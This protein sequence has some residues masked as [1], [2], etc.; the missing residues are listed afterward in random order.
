MPDASTDTN[1]KRPQQQ[2]PGYQILGK[3]GSG[4]MATVYK[5]R[6]LSLDR[7]V[8]IKVL[9]K[10]MSQDEKFVERFY[11]EGKAAAQL[12]HA[13]IV[14]ALDVAKANDFHY[15]VMEYVE[16]HTVYDE[17]QEI[18]RYDEEDAVR[19]GLEIARAM[20]HAHAAGFIHR[21]I[22]PK[23][24]MIATD[25]VA[26]LMDMGLARA[27]S[28]SADEEEKGKALG[29]PDYI[30]PEQI[31]SSPDLDFRAD[32]YAF[33]AS[34]YHMVTGQVPFEGETAKEVMI[35]HL[36]DDPRPAIE[37]NPR[38]SEGLDGVIRVCLAKN[39]DARYET[40]RDLVADLQ[41]ISMGELPLKAE[42]KL[43]ASLSGDEVVEQLERE[44][45]DQGAALTEPT[46]PVG[47]APAPPQPEPLSQNTWFRVAV[48][49]WLCA[50]IFLVLWLM[51]MAG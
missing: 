1:S 11:A 28:E 40:T 26:K 25:G 37:I 49:G 29:T 2:I 48:V 8:A 45:L 39:P 22:K 12:N 13:N 19:I 35:R 15:F 51:A 47:D 33:G 17:L 20:E 30:A 9:P 38:I 5:A 4:G 34:L 43:G 18:I 16:G 14:G 21:D 42:V 24:F 36:K 46:D 3:L 44:V 23:N 6:Q 27:K 32:I 50:L 31:R 10:R 41:A 7:I